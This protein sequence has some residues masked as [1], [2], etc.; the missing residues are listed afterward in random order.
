[1]GIANRPAWA[2]EDTGRMLRLA[3][4]GNAPAIAAAIDWNA[5]PDGPAYWL[6]VYNSARTTGAVDG[7]A[8]ERLR[9]M[10]KEYRGLIRSR[11]HI[12]LRRAS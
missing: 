6:A 8:R 7:K 2:T 3:L 11:E 12:A 9:A 5:A 10:S 1:M 4:Q